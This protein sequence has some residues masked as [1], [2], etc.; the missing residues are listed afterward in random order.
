MHYQ[1]PE[2]FSSTILLVFNY[3]LKFPLNNK[4]PG[5]L[6]KYEEKTNINQIEKKKQ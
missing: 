5:N 4:A 2:I 6:N 1:L 3:Q